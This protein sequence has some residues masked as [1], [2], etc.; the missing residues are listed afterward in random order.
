MTGVVLC[1]GE[2]NRMKT[3]KG[4]LVLGDKTW[5]ELAAEKLSALDLPTV[6]SI[7][8][9]QRTTYETHFKKE[10]LIVD[11]P[12][13]ADVGGPL[14]GILSVHKQFPSEDLLVLACDFPKMET[15]V[16]DFLL[17]QF[18]KNLAC[19]AMCFKIEK[20]VQP[21]C[22][23]YTATGLARILNIYQQKRLE[24][25]SMM[26]VLEQLQPIYL[27]PDKSWNPYFKNANSKVD[28]DS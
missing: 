2:S 16:L 10:Q 28:L 8:P 20:Q 26:Y 1:G 7:N 27:V 24:R 14:L 5:A 23:I 21:L 22:A 17:N 15:I 19:E 25:N 6:I 11:H 3:D 18:K 13:F 12:T 4:M 9:S